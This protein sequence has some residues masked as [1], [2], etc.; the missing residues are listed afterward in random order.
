[1]HGAN[2]CILLRLSKR[3][4]RL[5]FLPRRPL[6]L[7]LPQRLRSLQTLDRDSWPRC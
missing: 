6:Q 1:M 4:N 7:D 5:R 2:I 3:L